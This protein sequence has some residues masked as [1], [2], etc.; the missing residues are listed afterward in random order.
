[1]T[2]KKEPKY[3]LC[4]PTPGGI[5]LIEKAAAERKAELA[6]RHFVNLFNIDMVL[7][8]KQKQYLVSLVM[9]RSGHISEAEQDA[10]DGIINLLDAIDDQ[11]EPMESDDD[12]EHAQ[13]SREG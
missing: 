3:I 10:L 2:K 6:R 11:A 12:R 7:L 1:M 8:K 9:D 5:A 4:P 13:N